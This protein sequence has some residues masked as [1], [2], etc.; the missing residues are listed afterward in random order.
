MSTGKALLTTWMKDL[1]ELKDRT[2]ITDSDMQAWRP[3]TT[4]RSR[5]RRRS[6]VH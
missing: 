1:A 6:N 3:K 4:T 5:K 2:D